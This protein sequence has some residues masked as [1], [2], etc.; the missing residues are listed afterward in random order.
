MQI[1]RSSGR[2]A[3]SGIQRLLLAAVIVASLPVAAGGLAFA[4]DRAVTPACA[5][6]GHDGGGRDSGGGQGGG[7]GGG[8]DSS[9][10]GGGSTD[11]GSD[12]GSSGGHDGG[13]SAG[14]SSGRGSADD[15]GSGSQGISSTSDENASAPSAQHAARDGEAGHDSFVA[16]QVVVLD[17]RGDALAPAESLGFRFVEERRLSALDLSVL[18]LQTPSGLAPGRAVALLHGRLPE[19]I[20]DRNNLYTPFEPETAQIL[21]LP[22][23]HY[24][25]RMINWAGGT[26]CGSGFR[27][28]IIDS[29]V[30]ANATTLAGR[31]LHQRSF[32]DAHAADGDADHGTAIAALLIGSGD[33]DDPDDGGLMPAADLYAAAVL[34]RRGA[35]SE[36]SALSL[37]AALD[38]MVANHVPVVNI[39][40]SG[41]ANELLAVAVRRAGERGSVILAAA[42]NGGPAAPPAYP[43]ALPDV[44]AVTAVDQNGAIFDGANR[45]DYISFAAPGVG[46]WVAG[47]DG[48]GRY[49]TG[50]SFAVPFAVGAAALA[51]MR[52]TP[53]EPAAL[54]RR[55]AANARALGPGERNATFGYGLVQASGRCTEAGSFTSQ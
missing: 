18:V 8:K 53:A 44:I 33:A 30:A 9:G 22:A 2:F 25:R 29:T 28:G 34:E 45:G 51:V 35:A 24:A 11:G 20:A 41:S 36:A 3:S 55:L 38:W 32:V 46:I 7:S 26:D 54:R 6:D 50:T 43:A 21:S 4:I 12:G 14:G 37:A 52:G 15:S 27:I 17:E 47:R 23:P 48:H 13:G 10:G 42:G 39:S 49:Q 40:L 1:E 31:R 19:L 5:D 16:G